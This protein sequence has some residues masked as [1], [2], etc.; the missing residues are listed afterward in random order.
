MVVS[1]KNGKTHEMLVLRE[2]LVYRLY[3][4]LTDASFRARLLDVNFVDTGKKENNS[5]KSFAFLIE[6]EKDVAKRLDILSLNLDVLRYEHIQDDC[7]VRF[8]LLNYMIGNTDW[9]ITKIHNMKLTATKNL[10]DKHLAIPYD[11]YYTSLVGAGYS[12]P[13]PQFE[14][15]NVRQRVLRCPCYSEETFAEAIDLFKRKKEA[16]FQMIRD[17]NYLPEASKTDMEKYI[18]Q[19]YKVIEAPSALKFL[20]NNCGAFL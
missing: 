15:S 10:D 14:I 3:S 19:F 1:C 5:K 16:V 6:E 7:M 18:N 12:A 13:D 9:S 20:K 8:A 2:Y 17:F 11:F 4:L